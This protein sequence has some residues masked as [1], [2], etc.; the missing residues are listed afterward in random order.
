MGREGKNPQESILPENLTLVR[1]KFQASGRWNIQPVGMRSPD[2]HLHYL[3][4]SLHLRIGNGGL[5]AIET[6]IVQSR[7]NAERVV[8]FVLIPLQE[9]EDPDFPA[10]IPLLVDISQ[11]LSAILGDEFRMGNFFRDWDSP[12][13]EYDRWWNDHLPEMMQIF[14]MPMTRTQHQKHEGA[15]SPSGREPRNECAKNTIAD[16]F[17]SLNVMLR[18]TILSLI[19]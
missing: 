17:D 2:T 4:T 19:M 14:R 3:R 7:A 13:L 10:D 15:V 12:Y 1:S 6:N 18:N 9:G 11:K 5:H 8:A 16:R